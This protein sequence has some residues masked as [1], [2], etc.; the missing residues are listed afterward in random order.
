MERGLL[1]LQL[2]GVS[3]KL[4][5]HIFRQEHLTN[6]ALHI[7]K[8]C[9]TCNVILQK[10][11]TKKEIRRHGKPNPIRQAAKVSVRENYNTFFFN[12]IAIRVLLL[13]NF[14]KHIAIS[15]S[16]TGIRILLYTRQVKV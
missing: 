11:V 1:G 13:S 6:F 2:S 5:K 16:N 4:K 12:K 15:P 7:L 8:Y 9:H 14:H 10:E 3:R